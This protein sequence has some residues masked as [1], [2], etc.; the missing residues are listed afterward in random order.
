MPSRSGRWAT[1][2][3]HPGHE[4][5]ERRG[6]HRSLPGRHR[7]SSPGELGQAPQVAAT[8]RGSLTRKRSWSGVPASRRPSSGC[9]LPVQCVR[10][11]AAA[12]GRWC[13]CV[14]SGH[15]PG[16]RR[17]DRHRIHWLVV[18]MSA[19]AQ[20]TTA[21]AL[22]LGA[23]SRGHTR[24]SLSMRG[25]PKTTRRPAHERPGVHHPC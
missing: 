22:T 24:R 1:P 3:P 12:S 11:A 2:G 19:T 20:E 10:D 17:H 5:L 25:P 9:P 7:R 16:R 18:V 6:Q 13:P 15:C 4:R 14:R 8:L 23:C 21:A